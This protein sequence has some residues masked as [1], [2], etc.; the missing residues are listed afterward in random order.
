M[1]RCYFARNCSIAEPALA[2]PTLAMSS[3]SCGVL[4]LTPIA[5]MTLAS[6]S[7]GNTA[8]QRRRTWQSQRRYAPITDLIFKH[9]AWAAKNRGGA[10]FA[11]P[12][13][14]TRHLCIV[15]PLEQQQMTAVVN[16]N[17]HHRGAA[18][19]RFRFRFRGDLLHNFKSQNFL[20]R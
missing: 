20:H 10:R 5:P 9:L 12:D 4:P 6:N 15:K 16:D 19:F 13:L 11:D 7:I 3:S 17:N 18:F 8:L 1:I 2:A 14:H